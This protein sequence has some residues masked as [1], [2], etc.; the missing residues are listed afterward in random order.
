MG[1]VK[2]LIFQFVVN[3]G[4]LCRGSVINAGPTQLSCVDN[5]LS[6]IGGRVATLPKKVMFQHDKPIGTSTLSTQCSPTAG[7]LIT[8][9]P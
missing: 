5:A 8:L 4:A 1:L 9:C 6:P 7:A 3:V 2:T